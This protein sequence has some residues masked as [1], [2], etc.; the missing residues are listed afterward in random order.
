[1][2]AEAF[3][4][5][6]QPLIA[7]GLGEVEAALRSA[8]RIAYDIRSDDA[9]LR[10]IREVPSAERGA[11]FDKLRKQYP[12]R[13]EWPA[14]TVRIADARLRGKFAELGFCVT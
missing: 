8:I 1:M 13:R 9:A 10:K 6:K 5:P 14:T 2:A 3:P 12:V 11:H 4:A 7:P